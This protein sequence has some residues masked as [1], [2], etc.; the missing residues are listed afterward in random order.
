M[1]F[2]SEIKQEISYNELKNCCKRAELSALVQL[3]S[4]LSYSSDGFYLS[5]RSENP[6][7]S[8]RIMKLIKSLYECDV[9]LEVATK[10][11]LRK[12]NVYTLKV[13]NNVTGILEDLGIY[14]ERG[15]LSHPSYT[16]ISKDCCAR[17]YLAGAF[18]AYGACNSPLK[19]N[20][21]LE[22]SLN[23]LDYAS[24]IVKLFNRFS[25]NAKISKRRNRYIVYL[26]KAD[27][28]SDFLR[29]IGAHESLMNFENSR[30]NRDFK[31]NLIRLDNCEIANE[32]K[33]INA[34]QNQIEY[35]QKIIDSGK[36]EILNDKLKNVI[37]LR[38]KNPD[39]SLS[40]LCTLYEKGYGTSISRSGLKHRLNK[41]ELMAKNL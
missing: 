18:I 25:L 32:M 19:S 36:Y 5:V 26:K 24:F 20:Y 35:M 38:L 16:L 3:T 7:T 41:L 22:I 34:A 27:A 8:K 17:A 23:D 10:T 13:K 29:L 12:N 37:D 28:I 14:S 9:K 40:E 15:L 30:I 11:N 21:H 1:S 31:N 2:T 4:S 33:T 6:T 39:S